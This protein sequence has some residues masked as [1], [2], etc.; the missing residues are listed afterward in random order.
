MRS[1]DLNADLG[2]G[3][4]TDLALLD[5]V[6][7]CNVACGGH[8]GDA[9][10]MRETVL[11]AA[12]RKVA[13]G[14]HPSY[15][16]REGFGRRSGFLRPAELHAPLTEQIQNLSAIVEDAGRRVG[17]VKPHGALYNDAAVSR[18]LADAFCALV[19]G[20]DSDLSV[21]GPPDSELETAVREAG[22][23]F[24]REGFADR[25][26]TRAGR[27]V[28]RDEPGALLTDKRVVTRQALSIAQKSRVRAANGDEI[29][30]EVDSLCIHG[31]TPGA[32][33]LAVAIRDALFAAGIRVAAAGAAR[34]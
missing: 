10:S 16:D 32:V 27:L 23:A 14:A 28:A 12:S 3:Q 5:I 25:A 17:H 30:L 4:M 34:R 15:P 20:I 1:L 26:Y 21:M 24:L 8:A 18:E 29:P 11:A 22:L 19:A 2:E 33:S 7:S 31:D 13:I 6:S 9:E